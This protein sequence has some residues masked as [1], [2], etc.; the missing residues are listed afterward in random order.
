MKINEC[1]DQ[2]LFLFCSSWRGFLFVDCKHSTNCFRIKF[3]LAKKAQVRI[4]TANCKEF[5]QSKWNAMRAHAGI[6]QNKWKKN[7]FNYYRFHS[8]LFMCSARLYQCV[9][10]S[11]LILIHSHFL[12]YIWR[13]KMD[14]NYQQNTRSN[15]HVFFTRAFIRKSFRWCDVISINENDSYFISPDCENSRSILATLNLF[16]SA[17]HTNRASKKKKIV[18]FLF[19]LLIDTIIPLD[20]HLFD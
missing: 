16:D 4:V 7:E 2:W 20:V 10:V 18:R 17:I 1:G 3:S 6:S 13:Q 8:T 5:E 12:C 15:E 9:Y 19:F 11:E 14:K